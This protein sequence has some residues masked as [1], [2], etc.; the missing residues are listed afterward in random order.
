MARSY[1]IVS[2]S[3]YND[4]LIESWEVLQPTTASHLNNLFHCGL[5]TVL[6][7]F[8]SMVL[9]ERLSENFL[10]QVGILR[11][12]KGFRRSAINIYYWKVNP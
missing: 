12:L 9:H 6:I 10:I 7:I 1:V 4:L 5:P 11:R 2:L 8:E 3:D